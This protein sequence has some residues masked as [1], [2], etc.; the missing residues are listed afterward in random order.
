MAISGDPPPMNYYTVSDSTATYGPLHIDRQGNRSDQHYPHIARSIYGSP[1]AI[2]PEKF[3]EIDAFVRLKMSGGDV[4]ADQMATMSRS[5]RT[6][7]SVANSVAV[8]PL[9]GTIIP[10]AGGL[11]EASGLSS[12]QSFRAAFDEALNDDSVGSILL[13]VDSPGGMVDGV[14][15]MADHIRS[16]RGMKPIVAHANAFAASAA[17]WI[18]SAAD[19]FVVTPSGE[20]G[21]IGVLMTH[22]NEGPHWES[23]GVHVSYIY[24]GKHKVDGNPYEALSDDTVEYLQSTVNEYYD[25]FLGAVAKGRNTTAARV[26]RDFGEGRMVTARR[27][28][29]IGM[30]DRVES[31]EH[32]L[33][34]LSGGRRA[35]RGKRAEEPGTSPARSANVER[36][37]RERWLA[38]ATRK[39]S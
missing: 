11:L 2:H 12:L 5:G 34:R 25:M 39:E 22:V 16:S 14:P 21:S 19:E 23:Q 3:R 33:A 29:E 36:R 8:I 32:T 24:A 4:P 35:A 6:R 30:V 13:D 27:A 10:R 31:F 17:Y 7:Y 20:V 28:S 9:T 15:E 37:R 38:N 18:A 1:W 26:R